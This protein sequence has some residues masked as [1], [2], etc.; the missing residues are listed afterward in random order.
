MK[1]KS[2]F[3]QLFVN[4]RTAYQNIS[5]NDKK[6]IKCEHAILKAV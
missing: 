4:Y 1:N 6:S 2:H 5:G 3:A